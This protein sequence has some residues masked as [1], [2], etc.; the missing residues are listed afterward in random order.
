MQ[1]KYR[2]F[3]AVC[4]VHWNIYLAGLPKY[5]RQPNCCA[6]QQCCSCSYDQPIDVKL[7]KLHVPYSITSAKLF[8]IQQKD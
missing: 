8:E 3:G 2:T 5:G 7:W 6:L 4:I 1:A